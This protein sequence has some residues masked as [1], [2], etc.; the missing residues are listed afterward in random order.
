MRLACAGPAG[1]VSIQVLHI[2]HFSDGGADHHVQ[3]T[4]FNVGIG[5]NWLKKVVCGLE[6]SNIGLSDSGFGALCFQ[7]H[8]K[9]RL[10]DAIADLRLKRQAMN[11]MVLAWD[12]STQSCAPSITRKLCSLMMRKDVVLTDVH[13][14]P[15]F[16]D[17]RKRA[18]R[19]QR[20]RRAVC[21][22]QRVSQRMVIV[23]EGHV[24]F[25]SQD[26]APSS[27]LPIA[28]AGQSPGGG[29][30]PTGASVVRPWVGRPVQ[31]KSIGLE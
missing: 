20:E 28:R 9:E 3:P 7:S 21:S 4:H 29:C 13:G 10:V 25:L 5:N 2:A 15:G 23:G 19:G 6:A 18:G 24:E 27:E 11:P 16:M 26:G 31:R 17:W 12:M 8:S 14:M 1:R 22:D 30:A